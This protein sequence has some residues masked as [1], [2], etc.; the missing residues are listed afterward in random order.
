MDKKIITENFSKN[1]VS[2]DE[3]SKIQKK[4]AQIL[5]TSGE[6]KEKVRSILEIGCGTGAY[7]RLL[8]DEYK[9]AR[10]KAVDISEKMIRRANEKIIDKKVQ[11]EM[12]DGEKMFFKKKF[13]LITS[14]ASFQWFSDI[15]G[16]LG[17][18]S[19]FITDDG[20]LNFSIYGPGTFRELKKVFRIHF[21]QDTSLSSDKF[22]PFARIQDLLGH[23]FNYVD[24]K[25]RYFTSTFSNLTDFFMDVK[26][27]GARGEG[28]RGKSFLGK[29]GVKNMERIY[30]KEYGRII[31]T[32]EVY[33][34]KGRK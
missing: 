16:A 32:H 14:N 13:D 29:H 12:S 2:Y 19:E 20:S 21:G 27:S 7:T 4:C 28:L 33:F 6:K 22:M 5:I 26:K 25:K 8:R 15:G 17:R 31:A 30:M 1:A 34:C 3:H 9:R 24:V 11:F 10:I 18:F 23:Y